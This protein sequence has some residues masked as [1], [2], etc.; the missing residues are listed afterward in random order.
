MRFDKKVVVV[1]GSGRGIGR[2][3]ALAFAREGAD[4]VVNYS[5]SEAQAQ[6]V[7]KEIQ[8]LGRRAIA[9]KANVANRAEAQALIKTAIDT[10]GKVD[11][12]VNNAGI[13]RPAM[14]HKMTEE[15]WDSVIDVDLKGTFNC[16]QAVAPHMMERKYGKIVNVTSTAA[17]I[18]FTGNIN[19][20]AAKA[21]CDA[22]TKTAAKELA[23]YGINVNAVA[24]SV[25]KTQF[26]KAVRE[27]PKLREKYLAWT[28]LGRFGEPEEV[29]H[30]VLFLA[31]DDASYI[32][33]QILAVDGG[34]TIALA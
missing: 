24:P 11:I 20:A 32:T 12:L 33:G 10:F 25:I 14:L 6:E 3:I 22:V 19:Y 17:Q 28:L 8:A 23:R 31:S 2:A 4:V 29:A 9:V 34:Q 21:G 1:T 5:R 18:G 13:V 7:V 27:H 30:A 26:S 16:I 15:D